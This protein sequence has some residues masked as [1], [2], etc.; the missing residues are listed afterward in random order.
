MIRSSA[1]NA[2][3]DVNGEEDFYELFAVSVD[4]TLPPE[5]E[6]LAFLKLRLTLEDGEGAYMIP[7]KTERQSLDNGVMTIRREK[8]PPVTQAW[9]A[10]E[11]GDEFAQFLKPEFNIESDADEII[12]TAETITGTVESPV[13]KARKLLT[14]VYQNIDK[15]PVVSV[16]SALEVLETRVGDC[17]E[18]ATLLTALLRASGIP[19]RL[20]VG[21]V[22]NRGNFYYHAWTEAYLGRWISMDATMNQMPVDVSHISLLYGNLDKQVEIMGILGRLKI[23]VLE[24][25]Y[26]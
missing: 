1:A 19:A 7:E 2:S 11:M 13:L 17:N 23:E 16:P 4:K 5:P 14:W 21:L 20:S 10:D 25:G 3:L 15:R 18:H 24:F 22:Y 8:I 26:H 12:K 9:T 6:M